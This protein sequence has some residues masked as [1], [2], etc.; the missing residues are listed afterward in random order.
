MNHYIYILCVLAMINL[1]WNYRVSWNQ[2][3]K[4]LKYV[5]IKKVLN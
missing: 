5:E 3:L 2:C 4:D 1:M